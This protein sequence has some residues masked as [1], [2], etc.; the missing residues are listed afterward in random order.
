MELFKEYLAIPLFM[1]PVSGGPSSDLKQMELLARVLAHQKFGCNFSAISHGRNKQFDIVP[2]DDWKSMKLQCTISNIL[3]ME[4]MIHASK[5]Q[6]ECK[7]CSGQ[8]SQN[9]QRPQ[10]A[11]TLNLEEGTIL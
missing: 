7:S 6:S 2:S 1:G 9:F 5:V 11:R 3:I 8:K 10:D 4:G